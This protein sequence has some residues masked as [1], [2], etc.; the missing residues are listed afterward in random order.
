MRKRSKNKTEQNLVIKLLLQLASELMMIM[1]T[2]SRVP[3]ASAMT[4]LANPGFDGEP[5]ELWLAS[6]H[7]EVAPIFPLR[8]LDVR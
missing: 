8:K 1:D 6:N 5:T 7:V 4:A 3:P 2:M